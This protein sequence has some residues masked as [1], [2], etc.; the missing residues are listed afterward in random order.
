MIFLLFWL[1]IK[2]IRLC[3]FLLMCV[4]HQFFTIFLEK[5]NN[6]GI[7]CSLHKLLFYNRSYGFG[8][9]LPNGSGWQKTGHLCPAQGG[10][11]WIPSRLVLLRQ[12]LSR[13]QS[14]VASDRRRSLQRRFL[15]RLEGLHILV[16]LVMAL[17]A[18]AREVK[19]A[20]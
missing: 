2:L 19:W 13:P 14:M 7:Y 11:S 8:I 16:T 3:G 9:C 15:S 6:W 17:G 12:D 5:F 18:C 20:V 10:V 1:K 4:F